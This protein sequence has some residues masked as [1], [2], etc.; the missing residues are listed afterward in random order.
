MAAHFTYRKTGLFHHSILKNFMYKIF[1]TLTIVFLCKI[2]LA[3]QI[4]IVRIF[5]YILD[6]LYIGK[7]WPADKYTQKMSCNRLLFWALHSVVII[8]ENAYVPIQSCP[9]SL[10]HE[11]IF[12]SIALPASCAMED[13]THYGLGSSWELKDS[14]TLHTLDYSITI[15]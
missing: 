7:L 3:F 1:F 2:K 4:K 15:N 10:Q 13:G 8:H 12:I 9:L 11:T 5:C 6:T 14:S